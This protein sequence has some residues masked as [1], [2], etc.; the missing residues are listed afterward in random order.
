MSQDQ[1]QAWH[2]PVLHTHISLP[3][4]KSYLSRTTLFQA[5]LGLEKTWRMA[6]HS[7]MSLGQERG[8]RDRSTGVRGERREKKHVKDRLD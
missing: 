7:K 8:D 3:S 2:V 6:V 1:P 4:S 5:H